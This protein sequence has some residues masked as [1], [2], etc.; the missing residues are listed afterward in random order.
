MR[1]RVVSRTQ[2]TD[3]RTEYV[4]PCRRPVRQAV[5][6]KSP[7]RTGGDATRKCQ[8]R[9]EWKCVREFLEKAQKRNMPK[10]GMVAIVAAGNFKDGWIS[11]PQKS[12]ATRP[13]GTERRL[14]GRPVLWE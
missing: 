2:S 5:D 14:V 3:G 9:T 12:N 6:R 13:T 7:Q 10:D 1:G 11:V 4:V 8:V